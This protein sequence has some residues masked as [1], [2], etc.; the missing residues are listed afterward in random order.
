MSD[1]TKD[2]ATEAVAKIAVIGAGWWS[3]GWHLPC[4]DRNPQAQII[5]IIDS[6]PHPKSSLNPNLE[7]L[8]ALHARYQA[9]IYK[10]VDEF[11]QDTKVS[12]EL[13][14]VLIATPHATHYDVARQFLLLGPSSSSFSPQQQESSS[15]PSS[16]IDGDHQ[17]P[18]KPVHILM[19]K[20]MTTNIQHALDLFQ[21]VRH[22]TTVDEKDSNTNSL[23]STSTTTSSHVER[24]SFW[25]NHSANFRIQTKLARDT[26]ESGTIGRVRHITAFFGSPLTWIFDDPTNTGWNEPTEGMLG[27]GFAWGQSSHLLAWIYHVC[28]MVR[29]LEVYCT[30][31]HSETTGADVSHSATI[32]C[33]RTATPDEQEVPSNNTAKPPDDIVVLSLSGTTLLPGNAHSH[34]P[35]AKEVQIEIFGSHGCIFYRGNDRDPTS[36][37]LELRHA[38]GSIQVLHDQF[39]FENLD[40]EGFGPESLQNFVQLCCGSGHGGDDRQT[41]GGGGDSGSVYAGANVMDGLRSVQ[42]I[43]AMY[44]SNASGQPE[45]VLHPPN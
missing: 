11:L 9:P 10:S 15:S 24:G 34:P 37:R 41:T 42:T 23:S 14:G 18:R 20:P 32:R 2:S 33:C 5:A 4:L 21:L 38:D 16:N 13:D 17:Q 12:S 6:S 28:P 26:V 30:M 31:T 45:K 7:S 8:E 39:A 19:E 22:T 27:N 44:R 3:Q 29:P 35:V 25:V 36:G 1:A 40:N 43:D